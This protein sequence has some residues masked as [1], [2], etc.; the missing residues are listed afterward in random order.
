MTASGEASAMA[1][2]TPSASN[3]S[4]T[5]GSAP[6][7]SSCAARSTERVIAVTSYPA[8]NSCGT[9]GVPITPVAPARNTRI[10][11]KVYSGHRPSRHSRRYAARASSIGAQCTIPLSGAPTD[12]LR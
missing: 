6:T 11:E 7:A 10:A 5:T 4:Q 2:R 8:F 12:T 3:T 1:A 9:R